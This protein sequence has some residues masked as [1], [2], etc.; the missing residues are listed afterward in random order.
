HDVERF[1]RLDRFAERDAT[2]AAGH[3]DVIVIRRIDRRIGKS[4][5]HVHGIND[6]A[7]MRVA[8]C[9]KLIAL[10]PRGSTTK[11]SE[12]KKT[13]LRPGKFVA[14]SITARK[15]SSVFMLVIL[16]CALI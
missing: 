14:D 6:R 1:A 8:S 13:N 12:R 4:A 9:N 7:A 15:A 3:V 10:E 11:P 5:A 2:V 16:L